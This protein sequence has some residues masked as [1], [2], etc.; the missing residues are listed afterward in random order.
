MDER[1]TLIFGMTGSGKSTIAKQIISKENRLIVFD[2]LREYENNFLIIENFSSLYS[3]LTNKKNQTFRI[4]LRYDNDLDFEYTF[5]LIFEIGNITV[6]VEEAQL[7]ISSNEKDNYFLRLV[8]YGRHRQIKII[9]IARRTVEL[10]R[11]FRAQTNKIISFRQIDLDDIK[12]L[13]KFG[14]TG[15]ENLQ[16]FDYVKYKGKPV[17]DLHYKEIIF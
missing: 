17:K 16:K 1:I 13:E 12:N 8:R 7:Y 4:S 14:M 2:N 3:F 5:K 6:L 10:S 9:G 11:D 15:L